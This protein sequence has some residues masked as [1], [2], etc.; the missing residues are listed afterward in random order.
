MIKEIEKDPL[1]DRAKIDSIA[2]RL[3][4]KER[5]V[6]IN[7]RELIYHMSGARVVNCESTLLQENYIDYSLADIKHRQILLSEL[8]I[9]WKIFLELAF[10][11]M[12]KTA[13]PL[14]LL[15]LLS[16][17]DICELRQ[18]IERSPFKDRYDEL[19]RKS[20]TSISKNDPDKILY[21]IE[22]L[23]S[24]KEKISE[25]FELIFEKS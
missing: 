18:P 5:R 21:N 17:K 9:F 13:V 15:D 19:I 11:T 14:E 10:E 22:E 4:P 1:L 12:H 25:E 23:L 20:V 3:N 24:I 6:I 8:E 16:F 2:T 7:F